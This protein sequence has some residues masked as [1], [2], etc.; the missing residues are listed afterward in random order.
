M[1]SRLG[2]DLFFFL[3]V[4]AVAESKNMNQLFSYGLILLYWKNGQS[5]Y[6]HTGMDNQS[7]SRQSVILLHLRGEFLGHHPYVFEQKSV[8]TFKC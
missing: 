5:D 8:G 1:D 3:L 7:F 2:S 4:I 6:F